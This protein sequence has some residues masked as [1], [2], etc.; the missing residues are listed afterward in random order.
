MPFRNCKIFG[1]SVRIQHD[2][3]VDLKDTYFNLMSGTIYISP[4]V[5]FGHEVMILTGVHS[6]SKDFG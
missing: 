3:S 1:G 4:N 5:I 2:P 6:E